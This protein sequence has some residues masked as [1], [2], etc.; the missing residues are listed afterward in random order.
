MTKSLIGIQESADQAGVWHQLDCRNQSDI[1][2]HRNT[3]PS[4]TKDN[5]GE[6]EQKGR[7]TPI[8]KSKRHVY[9][10]VLDRESAIT[11]SLPIL[12]LMSK[13]NS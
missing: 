4:Q 9:E 2:L 1:L 6:I 5:T 13:L 12:Y 7:N 8:H 10:Q 11:L 3:Q